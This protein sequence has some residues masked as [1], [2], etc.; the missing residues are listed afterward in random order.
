MKT[1][2][3]LHPAGKAASAHALLDTQAGAFDE[4]GSYRRF[5]CGI[6]AF[7]ASYEA[8]LAPIP[9]PE[10]FGDWRPQMIG[11]LLRDDMA[12]AWGAPQASAPLN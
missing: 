5:L 2:S 11:D 6:E 12:D 4:L 8:A 9:W 3:R 7:R 1:L 10:A